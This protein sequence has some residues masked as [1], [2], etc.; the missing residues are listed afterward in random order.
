MALVIKLVHGSS[1]IRRFHLVS[2]EAS[3]FTLA[4]LKQKLQELFP[5]VP[6]P[7]LSYVDEDG[8]T[9]SIS[10]E[11]DWK[12]A[13]QETFSRSAGSPTN[14]LRILVNPG[15][16]NNNNNDDKNV[17]ENVSSTATSM[18]EDFPQQQRQQQQQQ[19]QRSEHP[20]FR[21]PLSDLEDGGAAAEEGDADGAH[22]S[23]H[24]H[25]RRHHHHPRA[26]RK[27][28][29]QQAAAGE[30]GARSAEEVLAGVSVHTYVTCDGCGMS[31]IVGIRYKCTTCF[32][33]DLCG[34]CEASEVHPRE[35][36]LLKIRVPI[37]RPNPYMFP[38]GFFRHSRGP[39]GGRGHCFRN[40]QA[41]AENNTSNSNNTE[42]PATSNDNN[43]QQQ[44]QG[45]NSPFTAADLF[46]SPDDWANQLSSLHL[47]SPANDDSNNSTAKASSAANQQQQQQ[48]QSQ[49]QQQHQEQQQQS[50]PN[51][52]EYQFEDELAF[53]R[54][55]GFTNEEQ[56]LQLLQT[57]RGGINA[58]IDRLTNNL[59]Q[60]F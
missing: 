7:H 13:V 47:S 42:E 16:N 55:M 19:Q 8:D 60:L 27:C 32:D 21:I 54:E 10:A 45:R 1:D 20:F 22:P 6:H 46:L 17:V 40:R 41:S 4:H 36:V 51:S 15:N 9:I 52:E 38:F 34:T 57:V 33:F 56:N 35:H 14:T 30:N 28:M 48:Q 2:G 58:I 11:E 25:R 29:R 53:L 37:Q 12:E 43:G 50:S 44:P 59:D 39:W 3:A 5:Y 24:R 49:P 31:P 26:H 23:R 18:E